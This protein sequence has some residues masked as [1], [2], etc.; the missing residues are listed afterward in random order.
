MDRAI[1]LG[2]MAPSG[3]GSLPHATASAAID[4]V[5][6]SF[7]EVPFCPQLPHL[8]PDEGM[9]AQVSG[10]IPGL[11]RDG[12][13]LWVDTGPGGL[14][15]LDGLSLTEVAARVEPLAGLPA[16]LERDLD[17]ARIIKGQIAGPV[18]LG[19]SMTDGERRPLLYNGE[20]ALAAA[21]VLSWKAAW[22]E[23]QLARSGK[24][25]LV[26]VDEPYLSTLGSGHFAF[27]QAQ[28]RDL[29]DLTLSGLSGLRGIHCCGNMDWA[30]LLDLDIDVLSFDALDHFDRLALYPL[31]INRFLARGGNL[32]WGMIPTDAARL[33][34]VMPQDLAG[35][36]HCYIERLA[37]KGIPVQRLRSQ[38]LVTPACGLPSLCPDMAE[39]ALGLSANVS[40]LLRDRYLLGEVVIGERSDAGGDG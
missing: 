31:E 21:Q 7:H 37:G 11:R 38:S 16:L 24:P 25:S 19:L 9:Y 14:S 33:E 3:I 13:R 10:G 35:R 17:R 18:S 1:L 5:T 39:R 40:A 30:V 26:F 32:A 34:K 2:N 22:L 12:D 20:F 23:K 27:G 4:A 28:A 15:D 36:L 6:A 29:L 8:D